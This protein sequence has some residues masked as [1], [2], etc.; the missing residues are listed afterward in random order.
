[1]KLLPKSWMFFI[2]E[3]LF[4]RVQITS[5]GKEILFPQIRNILYS[6][7]LKIGTFQCLE[8]WS[9]RLPWRYWRLLQAGQVVRSLIEVMMMIV[10]VMM[11]VKN[12]SQSLTLV[13]RSPGLR[14]ADAGESGSTPETPTNRPPGSWW[15]CWLLW[16]WKCSRNCR[17]DSPACTPSW[18]PNSLSSSTSEGFPSFWKRDQC[19][20]IYS[21]WF[22]P[23]SFFSIEVSIFTLSFMY[24]HPP[25]PTIQ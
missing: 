21:N 16:W 25:P 5:T 11:M 1:M 18:A 23:K 24:H 2:T 15:W 8:W 13:M 22:R 10:A 19:P 14:R 4:H 3:I 17:A 9:C 6:R 7:S 20:V 12:T